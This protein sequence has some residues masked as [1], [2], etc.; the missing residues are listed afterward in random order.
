MFAAGGDAGGSRGRPVDD[1]NTTEAPVGCALPSRP[2]RVS[3]FC[4]V[5]R[6]QRRPIESGAKAVDGPKHPRPDR[7]ELEEA[8]LL[9]NVQ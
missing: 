8:V 7:Q 9:G 6:V 3:P 2:L 1:P 4:L 5:R